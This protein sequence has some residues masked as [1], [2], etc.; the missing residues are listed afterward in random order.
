[1]VQHYCMQIATEPGLQHLQ[2]V[3]KSMYGAMLLIEPSFLSIKAA[4]DVIIA[5]GEEQML[6]GMRIALCSIAHEMDGL[7]AQGRTTNIYLGS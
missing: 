3:C 7:V 4:K 6:I 1:M 5:A 2:S